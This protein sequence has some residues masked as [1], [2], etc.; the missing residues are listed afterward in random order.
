M[1]E[2]D[3]NAWDAALGTRLP[4]PAP[5][6]EVQMTLPAGLASG[7]RLRLRGKGIPDPKGGATGNLYVVIQVRVPTGLDADA[8]AALD[9]L[10]EA[11]PEDPRKEL[12]Q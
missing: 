2:V 1:V 10:A 4:V 9:A 7:Q 5:D 6:G 8:E 11:G 3:V 12:F